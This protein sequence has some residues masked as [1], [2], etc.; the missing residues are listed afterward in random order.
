MEEPRRPQVSWSE[1]V[2]WGPDAPSSDP[3]QVEPPSGR[4]PGRRVVVALVV[5][6]SVLLVGGVV[7]LVRQHQRSVE[8]A[9]AVPTTAAPRPIVPIPHAGQAPP[10]TC[11]NRID[12][13]VVYG[14]G[15]GGTD[16]GPD[17]I[18]AFQHAYY[19]ERSGAAARDFGTAGGVVPTADVIQSGI[20]SI[21]VGS[22]HCLAIM[23]QGSDR[24]LVELTE[25]R[26]TGEVTVYRQIVTTAVQEGKTLIVGISQAPE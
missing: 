24:Y 23:P 26:P 20:D 16:N 5:V 22:T 14:N 17:A 18:L 10:G 8:S 13:Q 2:S 15:P 3:A 21:P 19:V 12:G 25:T 1:P 11:V 7:A 6:A 9:P 4:R